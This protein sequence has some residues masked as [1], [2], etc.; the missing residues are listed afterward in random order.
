VPTVWSLFAASRDPANQA[1]AVGLLGRIDSPAASKALALLA[2]HARSP[3]VRRAA[4]EN[5]DRRDRREFLDVLIA[6]VRDPI[7]YEVRLV[8][9]PGSPGALFVAGKEFNVRRLYSP[10]PVNL[11]AIPPNAAL[12]YDENGF[13]VLTGTA[14][15]STTSEGRSRVEAEIAAQIDPP[16]VRSLS[17]SLSATGPGGKQIGDAL[18]SFGKAN[19]PIAPA[20]PAKGQ[21]LQVTRKEQY[22]IP[23]GMMMLEAQKGA[24]V[25]ER[26]L[27]DDV[28][29][30]DAYNE[31]VHQDNATVLAALGRVTGQSLGESQDSWSRWWTDQ[32]GYAVSRNSTPTPTYVENVPIGYT[33]QVPPVQLVQ[34]PIVEVRQHHSC[35]AAGTSVRTLTGTRPIESIQVGDRV[36]TQDARTGRL[37]YQPVV[38]A[39]HNPPNETLR[40][41]AGGASVVATGIHRFW[42]AG[43]GWTMARDLKAGDVVRSLGGALAVDSVEAA[44][45]QPVYNL[46]VADSQSFFVGGPGLLVHDNSV[47]EPVSSPFDAAADPAAVARKGP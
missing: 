15:Y 16:N 25:A 23:I 47:V 39:F 36:L 20:V 13:A 11:P 5:L 17:Q 30:V 26:Q 3:E 28:A 10:P 18:T 34:G 35:F 46:Q 31:R 6:A 19:A 8:G 44:S 2:I 4:A 7:K 43:H 12:S 38:A 9:G 1:V 40:V 42:K 24:E 37:D 29:A 21:T 14:G 32:Q 22:R 33:P 27:E 41:N 45:T